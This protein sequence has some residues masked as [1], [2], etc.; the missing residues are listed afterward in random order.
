[1]KFNKSLFYGYNNF[2]WYV[3]KLDI[4]KENP[5]LITK[6]SHNGSVLAVTL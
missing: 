2:I 6:S 4:S 5:L 1:M 3:N